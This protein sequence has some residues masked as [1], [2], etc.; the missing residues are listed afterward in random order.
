VELKKALKEK[1]A[2]T[3]ALKKKI[4]EQQ[5]E[6]EANEGEIRKLI[7]DIEEKKNTYLREKHSII[8][9]TLDATSTTT[10][11]ASSDN[12]LVTPSNTNTTLNTSAVCP[13]KRP[14]TR[15]SHLNEVPCTFCLLFYVLAASSCNLRSFIPFPF[16]EISRVAS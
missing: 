6:S 2:E 13:R 9:L 1:D 4:D 16:Y 11:A 3:V 12:A 7:S 10:A 8:M 15:K 5:L 14:E